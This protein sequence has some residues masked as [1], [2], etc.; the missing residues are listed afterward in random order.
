MDSCTNGVSW[1]DLCP[2][3]IQ[4]L[5]GEETLLV[6]AQSLQTRPRDPKGA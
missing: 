4:D 3:V 5:L 1:S 2:L 6:L